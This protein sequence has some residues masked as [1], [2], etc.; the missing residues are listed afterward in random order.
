[1][2]AARLRP[3]LAALAACAATCVVPTTLDPLSVWDDGQ[4]GERRAPAAAVGGTRGLCSHVRGSYDYL[5]GRLRRLLAPRRRRR[6]QRRCTTSPRWQRRRRRRRRRPCGGECAPTGS[7]HR[8][9]YHA[10]HHG[11]TPRT[12][13][14]TPPPRQA[15]HRLHS[16]GHVMALRGRS[17]LTVAGENLA[18][19]VKAGDV[20]YVAGQYRCVVAESAMVIT[21]C[22]PT[23]PALP[24][25]TS[26][27]LP[28]ST[29]AHLATT[30]PTP[31][32]SRRRHRLR[33]NL[34]RAQL[35]PRSGPPLRR[36]R[37][38]SGIPFASR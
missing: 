2:S 5:A 21:T 31:G 36:E 18:K 10:M 30:R 29:P 6:R 4:G 11:L 7:L 26:P 25:V 13:F 33:Q 15:A 34:H 38:R 20:L 24:S 12:L 8:P 35:R 16:Y 22:S 14:P 3:L 17:W 37:T 19:S 28:T 23:H 32:G 27:R 1:M 9:T